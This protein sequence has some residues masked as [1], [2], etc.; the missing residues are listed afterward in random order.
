MQV[1]HFSACLLLFQN[2]VKLSAKNEGDL[3][4]FQNENILGAFI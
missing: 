2:M 3:V 4:H 1:L